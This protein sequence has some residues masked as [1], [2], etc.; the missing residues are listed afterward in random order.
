M[1]LPLLVG[2]SLSRV[3][4]CGGRRFNATMTTTITTTS[5]S[6]EPTP[7]PL[8]QR[9]LECVQKLNGSTSTL[10]AGKWPH[11]VKHISKSLISLR[12]PRNKRTCGSGVDIR[13][14]YLICKSTKHNTSRQHNKSSSPYLTWFFLEQLWIAFILLCFIL[15]HILSGHVGW[16]DL[17]ARHSGRHF[18]IR[19]L[20]GFRDRIRPSS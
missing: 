11:V 5:T 10:E 2:L 18:W 17:L 12:K 15:R 8:Y 20:S 16:M 1:L 6:A 3:A 19:T 13:V 4:P 9:E 14:G 7:D